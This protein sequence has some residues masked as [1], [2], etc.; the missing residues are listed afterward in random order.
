MLQ[1]YPVTLHDLGNPLKR[2]VCPINGIE[3][4]TV[5]KCLSSHNQCAP[6]NTLTPV[7]ALK[8]NLE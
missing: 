5:A 8:D 2:H 6:R 4:A 3:V 1:V 7:I